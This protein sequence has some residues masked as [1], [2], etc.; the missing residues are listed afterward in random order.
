MKRWLLLVLILVAAP[1][2]YF[3]VK[4]QQ[5]PSSSVLGEKRS[6]TATIVADNLEIPWDLAFLPGG[7]ILVTERVG[8]LVLIN[9]KGEKKT[10]LSVASQSGGE[11]GLLGITLHPDF[12]NNKWVYLYITSEESEG[13]RNRIE[14]YKLQNNNLTDK[15]VILQNLPGAKYHDGGRMEF[16]PDGMLYV[17]VGDATQEAL[18]PDT[19]SLA[20]KILRVKDDGSI[21]ADNPFGN[22][23]YSYGHRNPQGLFWDPEGRLWE[24]EH[25]RSGVQTGFDEIN[26]IEKGKNYGWPASQGN[27]VKPGTIGPVWHSGPTIAWAPASALYYKGSLYFGGLKG[28]ALYEAVISNGKVTKIKEHYKG[29]YGRI[30]SVRLGPDG[31]FYMTTSNRDGR[32]NV[33]PNDDKLIK[34]DPAYI[35][36]LLPSIES[37]PP[38]DLKLVWEG[39]KL[40][41]RF[42]V[43]HPNKGDAAL[44]LVSPRNGNQDKEYEVSQKIFK[45]GSTPELRKVGSFMWHNEH[46]HYHFTNFMEFSLHS[47]DDPAKPALIQDKMTYCLRDNKAWNLNLPKASKKAIYKTCGNQTQGISVGWA[48]VYGNS[49]PGQY[50]DMTNVPSGKYELRSTFDPLNLILEKDRSDNIGRVQIQFDREKQTFQIL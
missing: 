14:R 6:G 33:K 49:L 7:D 23:V 8:R 29:E 36:M 22:A 47:L 43:T 46:N 5:G 21:P 50:V 37:L 2:I 39:D 24:T 9:S 13:M 3:A 17:T 16:G 20:G 26:I 12:Q 38:H 48:G 10:I 19:N 1:I 18:A 28:E 31:Y 44:E 35:G 11:G 32:G 42:G 25:G 15:T 30:R 4:S 41:L 27:T 34:I 45:T 40:L